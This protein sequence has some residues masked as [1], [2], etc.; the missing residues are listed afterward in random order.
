MI[1]LNSAIR[2][3]SARANHSLRTPRPEY[4]QVLYRSPRKWHVI[5]IFKLK[6]SSDQP[7]PFYTETTVFKSGS[8]NNLRLVARP[9]LHGK[10]CT[11]GILVGTG[12]RQGEMAPGGISHLVEKIAFGPTHDSFTSREQLQQFL[13]RKGGRC[14]ALSDRES[15]L[16]ALSIS[17]DE[18]DSGI[19]LLMECA[20][21]PVITPETV[22]DGLNNIENDLMYLKY[23]QCRE[24]EVLELA[25]QAAYRGNTLGLPR[26]MPEEILEK[27]KNKRYLNKWTK[28]LIENRQS[29]FDPNKTCVV[30]IGVTTDELK[31]S[32]SKTIPLLENPSWEPA[33]A[34]DKEYVSQW[35]G[36]I[37]YQNDVAEN[38][39]SYQESE[40][41]K[42]Y[43]SVSWEAPSFHDEQRYAAHVLRVLLGGGSA[44]SSGG[45]GK[46]ITAILYSE[47]LASSFGQSFDQFKALYKEF[48]DS[49]IF[50]IYGLAS[51]HNLKLGLEQCIQVVKKLESGKFTDVQLTRAKRQ[52]IC[53][54]LRE[55]E[56]RPTMFEAF[57]RE[58]Q[59]F[60]HPIGPTEQCKSIEAVKKAD[61]IK[62]CRN[63]LASKPAIALLGQSSEDNKKLYD[64]VCMLQF[65]DQPLVMKPRKTSP[66]KIYF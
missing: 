28:W 51:E 62:V 54:Y 21:R 4:S 44:F 22:A 25:C 26:L 13:D 36:G 53:E 19:R 11:V 12:S 29:Y 55:M 65:N 10:F 34:E 7:N 38:Q 66:P 1:R 46:G 15:T 47:V 60:G 23:D 61:I 40:A 33:I 42:A 58:T 32:V 2:A 43:F 17:R 14:D 6:F 16:Y 41:N 9:A 8:I 30:G 57:A 45:P 59:V 48:N 20:F 56:V 31:S 37:V 18:L 49:G 64:D 24:K 50:T 5:F 35:T 39:F 3:I 27:S 52:L 63:L